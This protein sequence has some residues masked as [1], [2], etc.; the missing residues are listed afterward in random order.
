[1]PYINETFLIIAIGA[2]VGGFVQGLSG[3]AFGLVAMSFWTWKIDPQLAVSMVVFGALTGQIVAAVKFR[4]NFELRLL[5]P[6]IIGGLLGIPLGIKILPHLDINIF[7]IIFG[8]LLV[9]WCPIMLVSGKLPRLNKGGLL[10]N[11]VIGFIGGVIGGMSGFSGII[12]TLWCTIKGFDKNVQ[13][14]IIQ[15]FNLIILAVTMIIYINTGIV[16]KSMIPTFGIITL[17]MIIPTLVGA[18]L[19]IGITETIF[20]KVVLI[21][22]SA[23]GVALLCSALI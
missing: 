22:L 20:R 4:R 8:L 19:Y 10:A 14:A 18:R 5:F 9:I 7:K 2:V 16:T 13:R 17:A 12:P 23:S 15:N 3:F 11:G 6:F 21:L 1:M